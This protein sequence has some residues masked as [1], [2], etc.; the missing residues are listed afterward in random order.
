MYV[1][2]ARARGGTMPCINVNM[3]E[4]ARFKMRYGPGASSHTLPQEVDAH[5][6][7]AGFDPKTLYISDYDKFDSW[8]F[9][10]GNL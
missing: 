2:E 3:Y 1:N 5:P 7:A 4:L 6:Q 9:A 8:C 10:N